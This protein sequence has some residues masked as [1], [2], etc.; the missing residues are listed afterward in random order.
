M[1]SAPRFWTR[2]MN[3]VADPLGVEPIHRRH[4]ANHGVTQVG[5]LG[6][7]VVAPDRHPPDVGHRGTGL[8]RHLADGPVVIETRHRG[9]L[10]R[11]QIRRVA[12]RDERIGVRGIADHQHLHVTAGVV[13]QGPALGTED[14]AVLGEQI[15]AFHPLSAGLRA[16]EHR[17]VGIPE[18]DGGIVGDHDVPKQRIRAVVELHD[19]APE[20]AER[21]RDLHQVQRHRPIRPE[22]LAG[23]DPEQQRVSDLA[24]RTGDGDSRR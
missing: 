4:R 17:V 23:C 15:P 7:G 22:H 16:H 13:V 3:S 14:P 10:R 9:E 6:R 12:H 8:L 18:R 2:G 24:R 19:H 11:R 1:T 20:R 21:G 5:I